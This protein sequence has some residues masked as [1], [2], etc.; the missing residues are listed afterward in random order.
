M[1]A[2]LGCHTKLPMGTVSD[3]ANNY[4]SP[5]ERRVLEQ[6]LVQLNRIIEGPGKGEAYRHLKQQHLKFP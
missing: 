1:P 2:G 6:S 5:I 3:Q 4:F